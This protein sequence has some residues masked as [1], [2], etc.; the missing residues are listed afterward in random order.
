[1][2]ST[3]DKWNNQLF[4]GGIDGH[5]HKSTS[6]LSNL[7]DRALLLKKIDYLQ[8]QLYNQGSKLIKSNNLR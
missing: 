4:L 7:D 2:K 5:T 8:G 3:D 6:N 1:M